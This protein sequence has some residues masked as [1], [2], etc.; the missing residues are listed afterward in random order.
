MILPASESG[1][2]QADIPAGSGLKYHVKDLEA[3]MIDPLSSPPVFR[4]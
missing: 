1:G 2:S 4:E 3:S